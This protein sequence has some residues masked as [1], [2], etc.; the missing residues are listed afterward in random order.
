MHFWGAVILT[1]KSI[2]RVLLG[3]PAVENPP[4]KAGT[5]GL[6]PALARSHMSQSN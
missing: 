5:M 4:D 1:L 3:G 6:I 2:T